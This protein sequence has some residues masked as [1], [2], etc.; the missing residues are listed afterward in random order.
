MLFEVSQS[1]N[2]YCIIPLMW[3]TCS[4]QNHGDRKSGGYQG[5]GVGRTGSY[6]L[7]GIEF[8]FCKI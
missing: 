6:C 3:S 4:S 5:L 1:Q 8:Q 7:M 2:K